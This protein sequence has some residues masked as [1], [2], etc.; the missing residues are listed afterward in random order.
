MKQKLPTYFISAGGLVLAISAFFPWINFDTL[1]PMNLVQIDEY[2]NSQIP[3]DF[4]VIIGLVVTVD[5]IMTTKR[6]LIVPFIAVVT[7][8]TDIA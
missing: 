6:T 5:A 4:A 8:V 1:G 7:V 2:V 3:F